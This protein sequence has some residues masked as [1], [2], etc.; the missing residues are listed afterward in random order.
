MI[1][2]E[3][4]SFSYTQQPFLKDISFSVG[5]GEIFGFLGPSGA[6][7][8]T[9]QKILLG[10]IKDYTGHASIAGMEFRKADST[11]YERIGVDFEFPALYEKLTARQNLLFSASLYH[12]KGMDVDTLLEMAGL[13]YSA[14]QKVS[15]FSKGMKSR[16]GF[17]RALVH[18]PDVL[19]L[20]E[21]TSGLDPVHVQKMKEMILAQKQKGK[22]IVLTTHQMMD[23]QQLCDSVAFIDQGKILAIES[24][25]ALIHAYSNHTVTYT[26]NMEKQYS[27]TIPMETMKHD[28]LL[29]K[30]ITENR[31]LSIHSNEPTLNDIF[32]KLMER[33][34]P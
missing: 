23:A 28:L 33:N 6:G 22:T 11:F 14:D 18:D 16:L 19:F 15:T 20:D 8:S 25:E 13:S 7:K 9:M 2:V 4:L 21:P 27:A 10:L 31:L 3:N 30:L 1:Q 26:W 29:K 34:R 17:I 24:P 32:I 5:K 12:K